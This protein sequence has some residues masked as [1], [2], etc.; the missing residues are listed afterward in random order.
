MSAARQNFQPLMVSVLFFQS[1]RQP[2]SS[3]I[4][5]VRAKMIDPPITPYTGKTKN[6]K[7]AVDDL[8]CKIRWETYARNKVVPIT[9]TAEA[10]STGRL[11]SEGCLLAVRKHRIQI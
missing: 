11:V 3:A 8:I 2:I 4:A 7:A 5:Q 6:P 9:L 10:A 1:V